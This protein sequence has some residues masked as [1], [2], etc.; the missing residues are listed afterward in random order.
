LLA[1]SD[2]QR[3]AKRAGSPSLRDLR[4][5]GIAAAVLRSELGFT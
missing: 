5:S 4:E 3:L 1:D 2:G